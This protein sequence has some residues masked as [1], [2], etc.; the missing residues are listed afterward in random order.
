MR[1]LVP[2]L[3]HAAARA[4]SSRSGSSPRSSSSS[5]GCRGDPGAAAAAARRAAQRDTCAC[6]RELGPRPAA[7]RAVRASS[8]A[9]S[10]A[11]TSAAR[12]TSA[13]R[14]CSV[15]LG[16]LP[17][18]ARARADRLRAGRRWS[19]CPSGCSRRC[20]RNSLARPR[21]HGRGPRRPVGAD[22]LPRHPVHPA[23]LAEGR[24]AARPP[25]AATGRTSCCP[26]SRSAPSPWPRSRGSPARRVLEVLR[27]DY[28]RT[29]R[30]KGLSRVRWWSPS[31]RC[32]NAAHPHRDHHRAAV[33]HA[34]RRRRRHR[35]GV[36]L[37]GHRPAR[38]PVDLQPRLPGRAVRGVPVGAAC[39]SSSTSSSTCSMASSIPASAPAEAPAA[40]PRPRAGGAPAHALARL[41]GG[42]ASSRL[43]VAGRGGGAVARAAGPRCA[44]RCAARLAAPTLEAADGARAPA[45]HRPPRPRR[46][47]AHDL[48]R[49]RVAA[50]RLRRGGG[51]RP[52]RRRRSGILAGFRGGW[53]DT[54]IMTRRRRPA[55]LPVHPARHRHHRRARARASRR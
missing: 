39:S 28:V 55:R 53:V 17:A 9:T 54:V 20:R 44:S 1:A 4:R 21:R 52:R 22:V 48:R 23:A 32:K 15:V 24:A 10:C 26:R 19:R 37:A 18:T 45:R 2:F 12:S 49:A 36:R 50:G 11:A 40:A 8:S 41:A 7:A 27:A 31:T 42:A 47:L 43:L 34:A 51:G 33:R 38:H 29:A 25:A 14:R 6:A 3:G 46:A 5:C 13:S 35:D 16:Y 30:A